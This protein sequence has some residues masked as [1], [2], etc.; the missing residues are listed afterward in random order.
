MDAKNHST[1]RIE[2]R[3]PFDSLSVGT[4]A[5]SN[6]LPPVLKDFVKAGSQARQLAAGLLA[7]DCLSSVSA[8]A[9]RKARVRVRGGWDEP[10]NTWY[11]AVARSG[12]GKS[13]SG[14]PVGAALWSIIAPTGMRV[15]KS[16]GLSAVGGAQGIPNKEV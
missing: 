11:V 10:L 9:T 3:R 7:A 4:P 14:V 15:R 8:V 5:A 12:D 16:F 2:T 13:P 6:L 1:P